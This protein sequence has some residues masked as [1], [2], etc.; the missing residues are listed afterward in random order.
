MPSKTKTNAQVEKAAQLQLSDELLK[1]LIPRPVT[2][3]KLEG[4]FQQFK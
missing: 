2:P 4:I 1:Q 3:A